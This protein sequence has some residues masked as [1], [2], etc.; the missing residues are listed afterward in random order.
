M[1]LLLVLAALADTT[2]FLLLPPGAEANPIAATSPWLAILAKWAL[3]V[4]LLAWR[5]RY[6]FSLRA[7]GAVAWAVGAVTNLAAIGVI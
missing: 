1:S 2:T 3:V 6:A 4:G 5:H 7:F